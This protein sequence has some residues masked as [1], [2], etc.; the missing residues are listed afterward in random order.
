MPCSWI[1][2]FVRMYKCD[3][4]RKLFVV[5]YKVREIDVGLAPFIPRSMQRQSVVVDRVHSV[6]PPAIRSAFVTKQNPGRRE[7]NIGNFSTQDVLSL[8]I[9]PMTII[10]ST[11]LKLVAGAEIWSG[12]AV[13]EV[14]EA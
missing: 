9:L 2:V 10:W 3:S 8:L 5:F 4:R 14:A 12:E 13:V 6:L 1:A 7:T 11:E